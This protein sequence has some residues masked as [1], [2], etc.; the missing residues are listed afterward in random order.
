MTTWR[1]FRN[2]ERKKVLEN[3]QVLGFLSSGTYGRVYKACLRYPSEA[4][5]RAAQL[6]SA[7][8]SSLSRSNSSNGSGSRT[9]M[10]PSGTDSNALNALSRIRREEEG[11]D[12]GVYAIKKFKPEKEDGPSYSGISQ[13]AMREIAVSSCAENDSHSAR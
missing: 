3:Y 2:A 6:A 11:A 12:G 13:S 8:S 4:D 10:T 9:P 7:L 1:T 5:R